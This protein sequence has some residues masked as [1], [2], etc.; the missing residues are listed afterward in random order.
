MNNDAALREHAQEW[1]RTPEGRDCL[2]AYR[3]MLDTLP[4]PAEP[5]A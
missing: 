1:A 5:W 2:A 3:A 4:Q